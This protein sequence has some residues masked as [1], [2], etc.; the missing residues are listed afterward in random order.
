MIRVIIP[1]MKPRPSQILLL[2]AGYIGLSLFIFFIIPH[3]ES[4]AGEWKVV[5]IRLELGRGTKTG[6]IKIT[7]NGEE[8]LNLQMEA[9]E[10]SQDPEGK[11]RYLKTA[12]IIFF[13]KIMAVAGGEERTLRAGIKIPSAAREKTYRLFIEEI[14]ESRESGGA[15][16][17]V[18]IRFG[19]PIFIQ[20][21]EEEI[22]GEIQKLDLKGGVLGAAVANTG[23]VHFR[24]RTLKVVG[25]D[26]S[27]GEVFTEETEGWYLLAG[28]SRIHLVT[29]PE[30]A[31]PRTA[32][33]EVEVNTDKNTFND[34]VDV[35]RGG[36]LPRE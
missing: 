32:V 19:V 13:P 2:L 26:S 20:P 30:E 16:V 33:I 1:S 11:D 25:L 4:S 21:L 23:N 22:R 9:M 14:P 6:I 3:S 18:A 29:I 10:W 17:A 34:R 28:A 15:S 7:N 31:C 35:D 36:C 8:T 27:G 12:D 24:I 5:P